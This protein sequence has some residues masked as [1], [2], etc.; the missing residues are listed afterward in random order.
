MSSERSLL[1]RMLNQYSNRYLNTVLKRE[2][3]RCFRQQYKLLVEKQ[4]PP[5]PVYETVR[6]LIILGMHRSGT[7][8]LS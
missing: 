2:V 5:V 3:K 4:L 8:L 1:S 6:P 7:T